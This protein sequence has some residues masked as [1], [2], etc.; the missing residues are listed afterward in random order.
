LARKA[1]VPESTLRAWESDRGFPDLARLLQLAK[2]LGVRVER[3]AEGVDDPA[4][5]E[6]EA[7]GKK[8]LTRPR[9]AMLRT[10]R[11][12]REAVKKARKLKK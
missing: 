2:A 7:A 9:K 3:L 4:G 1:G 8:H 12:D 11:A 10:P 5:D 6:D